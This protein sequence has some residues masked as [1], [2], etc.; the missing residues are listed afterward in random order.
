[1]SKG[2]PIIVSATYTA[3]FESTATPRGW[4]NDAAVPIPSAYEPEP[5]PANAVTSL[6]F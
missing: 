5:D 4:I 1:M 2:R 3:P 6:D